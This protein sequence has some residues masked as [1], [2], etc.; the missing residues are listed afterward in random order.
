MEFMAE[1][2]KLIGVSL[3][4]RSDEQAV[5]TVVSG[6]GIEDSHGAHGLLKIKK[7]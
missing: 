1:T 6:L 5:H 4:A 3:E 2:Q 7:N